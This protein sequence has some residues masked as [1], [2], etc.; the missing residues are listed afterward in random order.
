MSGNGVW[1]ALVFE[2]L[3]AWDENYTNIVPALAES[4]TASDDGLTY[5]FKLRQGVTW[6][7]G[8]PFTSADVVWSYTTLLNPVVS[9]ASGSWLIPN[10]MLIKGAEAYNGG[11]AQDLP[12]LAA[13]DDL[14]VELTLEKASPLLLSQIAMPWILPKHLLENVALEGFFDDP[15]FSEK[16]VGLGPFKFQ[17]WE[18]DQF[19][20]VAKHDGYYR[21]APKL[22]SIVVRK[23]DQPSVAILSQQNGETDAIFLTSPDDIAT[24]Q[25]DANLDVFP[26]PGMILQSLGA[27][28]KPEILKDK[29]VRQAL[30]YA[31]DR[32]TIID[33]LY[34]NQ[35][36]IVNT[37][38]VVDWV[39]M[40]G[41]NTFDYDPDKAKSL[42]A[43]AG[44]DS[45]TNL[46]LWAYY[47]DPFTGQL[48]AAFQQYFGDVGV[49]T[50]V[51]QT[52]YENMQADV[53]AGNFGL[54]Y[55]GSSRGPDPN[56]VYIYF[57]S[58]SEYN[59]LYSDPDV[60]SL[61]DQGATTLDQT[62]RGKVYNE[63]AV[64]LAD[65][66]FWL[67]LWAPLRNWAVTKSVSGVNGKM[68]TPGLH[69]PFY[70]QAETWTKQG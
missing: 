46:D 47:T 69:I 15:F 1:T 51:Q 26:G 58:K 59:T 12:G 9:K 4:W 45:G 37:P 36:E 16:L 67:M 28:N 8:T 11:T 13:P 6:H 40:D 68:G 70:S 43:E 10:L 31:I 39:P 21:G 23:F 42:L 27:G 14:N 50:A 49:K 29:R 64:K 7:D 30:L 25:N 2:T 33:T 3:V 56:N 57:H 32:P 38:F 44:W 65:L 34:K 48:L 24:V 22:D 52:D 61:L 20:T 62:E 18:R 60:D 35:A 53:D 63:L 55:Q 54:L 66:S 17:Q 5:N 41:V 19:L